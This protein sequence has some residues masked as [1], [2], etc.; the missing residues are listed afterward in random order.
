MV[1]FLCAEI[2]SSRLFAAIKRAR[3]RYGCISLFQ[4]C[5]GWFDHNF[6][7]V[8]QDDNDQE[9]V[10]NILTAH[11]SPLPSGV[12]TSQDTYHVKT[13]ALGCIQTSSTVN[14]TYIAE[15]IDMSLAVLSKSS[16]IHTLFRH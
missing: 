7:N 2:N 9:A 5:T 1:H 14:R 3:R 8:G 15:G 16:D 10:N 13:G 6:R 11:I 12:L 4:K